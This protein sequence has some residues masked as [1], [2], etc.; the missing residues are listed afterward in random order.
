VI[1]ES[2]VETES[3]SQVIQTDVSDDWEFAFT[4]EWNG[5]IALNYFMP[6]KTA[7]NVNFSL[8][9]SYRD[10]VRIFPQ[11]ESL[12]DEEAYTLYD[13]S[14][15]WNSPDEHWM[16]GLHGKNLSDEEYRVGGYNFIGL[17]A[18]DSIVGY[19]GNPRTVALTANYR[20]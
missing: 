4:P 13:A 9:A 7:G 3:G 19:Y 20:F 10:D 6:L 18:E 16:V 8:S 2:T 1:T 5:N 14:V 12:V 11:V 17:G 15:V